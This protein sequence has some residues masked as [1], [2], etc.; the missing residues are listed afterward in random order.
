MA[1]NELC[2]Y[3]NC[4]DV[5]VLPTNAEGCCNAIIEAIACGLPIISSN[6][7]F[8]NEILN[9]NY[10]IR[11]NEESVEEIYQAIK[12]IKEDEVFR[13]KMAESALVASNK[14]EISNRAKAIAQFVFNEK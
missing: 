7:S 5:F 2:T 3:L 10:S 8:N 6:K 9:D 1:H 4:A 14:F 11:I 13:K 12:L